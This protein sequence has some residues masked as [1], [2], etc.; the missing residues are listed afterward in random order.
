MDALFAQYLNVC[1]AALAENRARF[2]F[3]QIWQAADVFT[4][5]MQVRVCVRAQ[6]G[7]AVLR[8]TLKDGVLG[9]MPAACCGCAA[10]YGEVS[11]WHVDADYLE[12]VVNHRALYIR[13]PA[14]LDW[15]WLV[16]PGYLSEQGKPELQ[17][18]Q[19]KPAN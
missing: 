12:N 9:A 10:C 4:R 11:E 8:M 18:E 2:P 1:N 15:S 19:E 7:D 17:A 16:G 14:L 5:R 6:T 3:A 13:Q